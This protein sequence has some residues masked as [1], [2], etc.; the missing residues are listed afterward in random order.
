M[1]LNLNLK[2]EKFEII[3]SQLR[4]EVITTLKDET[5]PKVHYRHSFLGT[6]DKCL[7]QHP[8]TSPA[9]VSSHYRIYHP[10]GNHYP[11]PAAGALKHINFSKKRHSVPHSPHE[12]GRSNC[13]PAS[14]GQNQ[15][16]GATPASSREVS[17]R[18]E[19]KRALMKTSILAINQSTP[20]SC[21]RHM[22]TIHY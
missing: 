17:E 1:N 5:T 10:P 2:F 20:Q 7:D 18:S 6:R 19:A 12:V 14:R 13:Q 16:L 9:L 11:S 4:R 15:P 3:K 21:Y 22:A 8:T